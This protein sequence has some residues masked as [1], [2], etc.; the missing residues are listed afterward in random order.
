MLVN[1]VLV[2]PIPI[3]L[4]STTNK[5]SP[6]KKNFNEHKLRMYDSMYGFHIL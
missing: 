5:I 3:H 4:Q 2:Q 6:K 1:G